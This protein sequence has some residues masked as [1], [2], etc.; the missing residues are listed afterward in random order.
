MARATKHKEYNIDLYT[1]DS[2]IFEDINNFTF[3]YN[4]KNTDY[5]IELETFKEKLEE[6]KDKIKSIKEYIDKTFDFYLIDLKLFDLI[7][8]KMNKMNSKLKEFVND[9]CIKDYGK[10]EMETFYIYCDN[11][12]TKYYAE[13][14]FLYPKGYWF[15]YE[16]IKSIL[17]E[18][19]LEHFHNILKML[20][21]IL[22][23]IDKS[24]ASVDMKNIV[25]KLIKLKMYEFIEEV[26]NGDTWKYCFI[27]K[28]L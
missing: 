4:D 22:R 23:N 9:L 5:M 19:T 12:Y 16:S 26:K 24:N 6:L 17:D 18:T 15:E 8:N 10:I 13:S 2:E 21:R 25:K 27:E 3:D 20:N 14:L 1:N 28:N 11:Y 7:D